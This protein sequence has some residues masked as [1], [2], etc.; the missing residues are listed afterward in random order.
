MIGGD[1]RNS[2]PRSRRD[3]DGAR[4]RGGEYSSGS[5]RR[6]RRELQEK[7]HYEQQQHG[8]DLS[9]AQFSGLLLLVLPQS[10]VMGVCVH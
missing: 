2:S 9:S 1:N 5:S 3:E 6:R 8:T 4:G 7:L 10:D